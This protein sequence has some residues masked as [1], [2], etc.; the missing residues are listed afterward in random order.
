MFPKYV[1]RACC[2]INNGLNPQ[3]CA[4]P[5]FPGP[6]SPPSVRPWLLLLFSNLL[7]PTILKYVKLILRIFCSLAVVFDDL[8]GFFNNSISFLFFL[9]FYFFFLVHFLKDY[10]R[11]LSKPLVLNRS[12]DFLK[13]TLIKDYLVI[14]ITNT[15]NFSAVSDLCLLWQMFGRLSS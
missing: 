14:N 4:P 3:V 1:N 9:P 7:Q 6:P 2:A 10:V 11:V 12:E 5:P 8:W 15:F 13:T